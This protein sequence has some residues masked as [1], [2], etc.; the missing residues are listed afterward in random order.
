MDAEKVMIGPSKDG[1][2]N[3]PDICRHLTGGS[4]LLP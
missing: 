1:L 3:I 4:I 2:P